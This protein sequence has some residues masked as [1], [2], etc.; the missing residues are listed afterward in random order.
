MDSSYQA[1]CPLCGG[2]GQ[3]FYDDPIGGPGLPCACPGDCEYG[4]VTPERS[5]ELIHE[6]FG[7]HQA[8]VEVW[9]HIGWA[10][11]EATAE[12]EAA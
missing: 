4:Y 1:L 10:H 6:H 9:E 11:A 12:S 3:S 7:W 5:I 8:W 2:D